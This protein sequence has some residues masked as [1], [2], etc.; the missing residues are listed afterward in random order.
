VGNLDLPTAVAVAGAAVDGHVLRELRDRGFTGLRPRHGYVVQRLVLGPDTAS[1]MA[2]D[3][4]VS[5]HVVATI[6]RELV[7]L[8]YAEHVAAEVDKRGRPVALTARGQDAVRATTAA[9]SRLDDRLRDAVGS[10]QT[11]TAVETLQALM[12]LLDVPVADR[13]VKLPDDRS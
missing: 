11:E 1:A 2:R 7:A 13:K 4:G 12:R 3:L 5:Q 10:P 9:W 8:G 6:V